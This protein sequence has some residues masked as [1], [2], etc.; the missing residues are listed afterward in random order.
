M[1]VLRRDPDR[2]RMTLTSDTFP[3]AANVRATDVTF[4][5]AAFT[6]SPFVLRDV[7]PFTVAVRL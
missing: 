6:G 4:A 7:G 5:R 3:L 2:L 1:F